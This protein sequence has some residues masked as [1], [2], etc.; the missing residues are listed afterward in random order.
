MWTRVN[1]LLSVSI[2]QPAPPTSAVE[3]NRGSRPRSLQNLLVATK[4][5]EP[6]R[7]L[8]EPFRVGI[9]PR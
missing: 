6:E 9:F 5:D 2:L 7:I 3:L 1:H 4:T 8:I